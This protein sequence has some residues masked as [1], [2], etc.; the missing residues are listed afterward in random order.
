MSRKAVWHPRSAR[1]PWELATELRLVVCFQDGAHH[2]L[3]QLIPTR[4]GMPSG[5]SL[6]IPFRDVSAAAREP[7]GYRSW[8]SGLDDL[9]DLTP[10]TCHP[11]SPRLF[12]WS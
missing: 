6:P 8:R 7:I 5:R 12:P 2:F 10:S 4:P 3:E 11:R 1:K 9:L